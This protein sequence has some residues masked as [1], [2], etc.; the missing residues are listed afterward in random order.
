MFISLIHAYIY[1]GVAAGI[2]VSLGSD[3][4]VTSID[5]N[6]I[7]FTPIKT[8]RKASLVLFTNRNMSEE[9]HLMLLHHLHS[10]LNF[11]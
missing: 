2:C 10:Y 11:M 7:T 6:R 5:R 1:Q 4:P 8:E 9:I 3:K